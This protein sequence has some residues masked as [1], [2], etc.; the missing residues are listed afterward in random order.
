MNEK[1]DNSTAS[2][3][4]TA[5]NETTEN[6]ES[7]ETAQV[8]E[9]N[10]E[11]TEGLLVGQEEKAQESKSFLDDLPEELRD[12]RTLHNFKSV[13]DLAKSYVEARKLMGKRLSDMTPEEISKFRADS[14]VPES[15]E[16]YD[17]GIE[18]NRSCWRF[19]VVHK[20]FKYLGSY[21]SYN[22]C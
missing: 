21:I 6:L 16:A 14:G 8:E 12:D 20:H 3:E 9:Q 11:Q 15:P 10:T 1:L 22:L 4:A 7:K 17:F 5:T 2:E 13:D 18:T 19:C